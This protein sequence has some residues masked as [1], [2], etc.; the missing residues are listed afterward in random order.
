M[1]RSVSPLVQVICSGL[2]SCSRYEKT[3]I[4]VLEKM[5]RGAVLNGYR[6]Q[7]GMRGSSSQKKLGMM[8]AVCF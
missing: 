1:P 7:K 4:C 8:A 3:W 2:M 5:R 6:D